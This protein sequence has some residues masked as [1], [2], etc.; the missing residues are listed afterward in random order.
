M[1]KAHVFAAQRIHGDDTTVRIG[2]GEDPDRGL[3]TY[4]RRPPFGGAIRRPQCT[5]TARS[6]RRASRAASRRIFGIL[7][8]DAVQ[9]IQRALRARRMPGPITA[10]R[11]AG[12]HA[13]RKLFELADVASAR[14]RNAIGEITPEWMCEPSKPHRQ[15]RIACVWHAPSTRLA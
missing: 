1:I 15:A 7:Q 14:P 12:R 2:Q 10:S 8:A 13:R 9:R 11:V 6:R 5:S 3:W 4:V